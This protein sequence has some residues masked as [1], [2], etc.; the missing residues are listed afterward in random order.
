MSKKGFTLIELLVTI[1]IIT[2]LGSIAFPFYTGYRRG[3]ARSEATANLSAL[4]MCM[5]EYFSLNGNYNLGNLGT[6][7]AITA[8]L[9]CFRPRKASGGTTLKYNYSLASAAATFTATAAGRVGTVVSGD[10]GASSL[11]INQDGIKSGPW[12]D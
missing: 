11:T 8:A 12:P 4:S 3:A 5:D 6:E 10:T 2:I 9:P 7:A 1:G